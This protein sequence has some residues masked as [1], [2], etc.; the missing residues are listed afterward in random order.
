MT[1]SIGVEEELLL[2]DPDTGVPQAVAGAA[3]RSAA[4]TSGE[5]A[6]VE[7]E[8]MQQQLE[9]GTSPCEDADELLEEYRANK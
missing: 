8:L 7:G 5:G 9:T 1:R 4:E 6:G 3:L 2:V